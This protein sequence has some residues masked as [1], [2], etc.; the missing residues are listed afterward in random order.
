MAASQ[1]HL[2]QNNANKFIVIYLS[3]CIVCSCHSDIESVMRSAGD[4]RV[5]LESFLDRYKQDPLKK[6]AANFLVSSMN[7]KHYYAGERLDR[8][9]KLFHVY[10]S[11][12]KEGI[13]VGEP[14][15]VKHIWDSLTHLYGVPDLQNMEKV[16]DK[17]VLDCQFLTDNIESSFAAWKQA[18]DFVANDFHSFCEY[19]LPYKVTN[20]A[21]ENYKRHYFARYR[22]L[23]DSAS[24][25]TAALL[26]AFHMEFKKR[27]QFRVSATMWQYPVNLPPSKMELAHR[28]CC[29]QLTTY[30]AQVMRSCGLPVAIDHAY[31]W[32]NRSSGHEWNVLMLKD[33]DILP[34]DAFGKKR[35]EFAYKPTKIFRTMFS[36][37]HLPK[38]TPKN[39]EVP[40]FLANPYEMDVTE[41]Y[42]KVYDITVECTHEDRRM[43]PN[44]Y[45]VICVFD[46]QQWQP[47]H[48]GIIR[49][50][51]MIFR[52]MMPGICYM[53]V[54]YEN[55]E[56]FPASHPFILN[57]DGTVNYLKANLNRLQD[58]KLSRKYPYFD[59]MRKHAI[60]MHFSSVQVANKADFSD[61]STI[62]NIKGAP[63]DICD[64]I[65]CT[66]KP[67]RYIR[68]NLSR[69]RSGNLAEVEFYG[70]KQNDSTESRLTGIIFGE[71]GGY[72][73]AMDGDY[74]TYF[75]KST[76]VQG[77]VGLD[78][79]KDGKSHITRI[80]F[81]PRSD[82]NFIL[83]G[84]LYELK[85]WHDGEWQ[86]VGEKWA[87]DLFLTF[88][89]VPS[90][91]LYLLSNLSGGKEERVFTF[92][93]GEQVW[94]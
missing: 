44:R 79:G 91:A 48:W 6:K 1:K 36:G 18:P 42:G 75:S 37:N 4:N 86:T 43:R 84:N 61:A 89:N 46:N 27:Q 66:D 78:L 24:D 10:D 53:A 14:A 50:G 8:Y 62:L 7:D 71:P 82:T 45:A 58:M 67:Y 87:E 15:P 93:N 92:E 26:N 5:E 29:R 12:Y 83:P 9:D 23:V 33:G 17:Q 68:F 34:F 70:K 28:G 76:K 90:D 63:R 88:N 52:K 65:V 21:P 73:N 59:Q 13:Y 69:N 20:E 25:D 60:Q 16:Y 2:L 77:Y 39:G 32:G 30:C 38:D 85:Y 40:A 54:Y 64:S 94:W 49:H 11:L 56:L 72:I 81:A 41:Q 47:V 74:N 51:Q 22:M 3:V 57:T 35:I 80:R 31:Q 55:D 19:V